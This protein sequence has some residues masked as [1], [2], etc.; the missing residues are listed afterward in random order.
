MNFKSIRLFSIQFANSLPSWFLYSLGTSLTPFKAH[1]FIAN[2][3]GMASKGLW[4]D[5]PI[6][7]DER[8]MR[9]LTFA[10]L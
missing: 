5:V 8:L 9:V 7:Q 3:G 6:N 4:S 2:V 1:G 10:Y